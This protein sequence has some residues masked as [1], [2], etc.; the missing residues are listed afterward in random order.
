MAKTGNEARAAQTSIPS[1]PRRVSAVHTWLTL[2]IVLLGAALRIIYAAGTDVRNVYDDHFDVT[3]IMVN[4]ARWPHPDDGWQCYQP[5]LFHAVGA[6]VYRAFNPIGP[7]P[8]PIRATLEQAASNAGIPSP[9]PRHN[10]GRKAIQFISVVCGIGTLVIAWRS[11]R[12]LF[13]TNNFAQTAGTAFVALLPRHIYMSG[14]ATNDAMTYLWVSLCVHAALHAVLTPCRDTGAVRRGERSAGR[15][16]G[17]LSWWVTAGVAAALAMWTKHYGLGCI[18]ILSVAGAAKALATQGG[19]RRRAIRDA[20]FA[21]A[22]GLAF[23]VWPYVRNYVLTGDPVVSPFKRLPNK[24]GDQLPGEL[25][26]ISWA[27]FRFGSLIARPWLHISTVDS[28]WTM[29]YAELWFDHG[30]AVTAYQYRPWIEFVWPIWRNESLE[31]RERERRGLTWDLSVMPRVF[32]PQARVL[33]VLGLLPTALMV[34]GLFAIWRETGGFV[35]A[36]IL[37]TS[38][39]LG[40]FTPLF[41]TI[42]QPFRSSIKSTFV[43]HAL[44]AMTILMVA[45]C[46][47]IARSR[48]GR[49]IRWVLAINLALLAVAVIW[50][51]GYLSLI[52]PHTPE[53]FARRQPL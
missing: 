25:S 53:Y 43:L 40:V 24:M 10:A 9:F 42:R 44:I 7:V 23:G 14:M 49:W 1:T 51:F 19:A 28:F 12:L 13:P 46:E 50:H 18:A 41:Q 48:F 35:P 36:S 52:F 32:V 4:E 16:A 38:M 3:K 27:S 8:T 6:L 39:A 34:I 21:I 30:T 31:G 15:R 37:L 26:A 33:Y 17:A 29:L 2:G 11:L 5:P 20:V 22:L 45:G 47:C